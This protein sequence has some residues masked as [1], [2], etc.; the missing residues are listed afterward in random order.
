MLNTDTPGSE[1]F[2]AT[3]TTFNGA[4]AGRSNSTKY[5]HLKKTLN[6]SNQFPIWKAKWTTISFSDS[7]KLKNAS[8]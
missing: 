1:W 8:V 5:F 6:L 3:Y 7:W 4:L 2:H